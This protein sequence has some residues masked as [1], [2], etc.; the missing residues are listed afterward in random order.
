MLP[1]IS[2]MMNFGRSAM[3]SFENSIVGGNFNT[4]TIDEPWDNPDAE[5]PICKVVGSFNVARAVF[6]CGHT[7]EE[8]ENGVPGVKDCERCRNDQCA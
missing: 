7:Q 4:E 2:E 5:C 8:A 3:K 1:I 6:S